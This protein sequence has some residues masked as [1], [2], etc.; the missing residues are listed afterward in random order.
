MIIIVT[1]SYAYKQFFVMQQYEDTSHVSILQPQQNAEKVF[2][3][4][5]TN[6][7]VAIGLQRDGEWSAHSVDSWGYLEPKFTLDSW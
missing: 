5:E 4:S 6:F 2:G 7:N 1:L 3:H